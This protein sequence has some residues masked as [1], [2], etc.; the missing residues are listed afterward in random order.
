[1]TGF[2]LPYAATFD[3]IDHLRSSQTPLHTTAFPNELFRSLGLRYNPD[4]PVYE[5]LDLLLRA[6]AL[7]G[8]VSTEAITAVYRRWD[9]SEATIH[10]VPWR[11]WEIAKHRILHDLDRQPLLLPEGSASRLFHLAGAH[12]Q[13][14]RR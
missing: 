7:C 10:A 1:M 14:L 13:D 2:Q 11:E 9:D 3:F 8:V 6:A 5:D 12:E 4:L